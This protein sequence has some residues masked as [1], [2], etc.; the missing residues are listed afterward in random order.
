MRKGKAYIVLVA[1]L[2]ALA[3]T[4]QTRVSPRE[5]KTLLSAG[6]GA[7]LIDVRSAEEFLELRIPGAFLLPYDRIDAK[8]AAA[9]IPSKDSTVIVYCRSGRRSAIAASSLAKLGYKHV[10]DLGGIGEWPFE[11]TSGIGES[12]R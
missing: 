1:S 12:G 8:S 4:A 7:V 3:A 9:A 5:A 2:L 10:L 6:T 11:T